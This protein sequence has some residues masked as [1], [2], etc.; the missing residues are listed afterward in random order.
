MQFNSNS[1]FPGQN[2]PKD[3][4]S[5]VS[6]PPIPFDPAEFV[7]CACI[8][9]RILVNVGNTLAAGLGDDVL[10]TMGQNQMMN[11]HIISIQ[12]VN[13]VV[14]TARNV[15]VQARSKNLDQGAINWSDSSD[16]SSIESELDDTTP[17][18]SQHVEGNLD[19]LHPIYPERAYWL[20]HTLRSAIY[21][22]VC[23]GIVLQKISPPVQFRLPGASSD[24]ELVNVEWETTTETVAI[25]EMNW[26]QIRTQGHNLAENPVKVRS[27]SVVLHSPLIIELAIVRC[28]S[29]L[30]CRK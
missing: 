14:Q 10:A 12:G 3:Q 8:T 27:A 2:L 1:D 18:V 28:V 15:I 19:G 24:S 6:R 13:Y 20:R 21:G 29:F 16:S 7:P 30:F 23:F 9:T 5:V 17:K 26:D 11:P 4:W 22:R 25:K